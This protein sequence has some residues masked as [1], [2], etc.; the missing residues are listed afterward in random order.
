METIRDNTCPPETAMRGKLS[1]EISFA[2]ITFPEVVYSPIVPLPTSAG[3]FPLETKMCPP[4]TAMS[5]GLARPEIRKGFTVAPEVVYALIKPSSGVSFTTNK[6]PPDTAMLV[7]KLSPGSP[8]IP[9]ISFAFSTFPEVVYSPIV[10]LPKGRKL[11]SKICAL[12]IIG[13]RTPMSRITT[14]RIRFINLFL[15]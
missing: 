15:S 11:L 7:G 14:W 4:D 8:E 12:T 13:R 3:L 10:P 2:F 5:I 9:E 1:P 6:F